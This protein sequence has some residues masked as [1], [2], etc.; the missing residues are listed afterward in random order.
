MTQ[1]EE[2]ARVLVADVKEDFNPRVEVDEDRMLQFALLLEEGKD[3][4]RP[5]VWKSRMLVVDGRTR[6]S[7]HRYLD[8]NEMDVIFRE[9]NSMEDALVDAYVANVSQGP[10]PP[11]E[12]DT[13]HTIKLLLRGGFGR[14]K[15]AERLAVQG[16]LPVK[17]LR[18]FVEEVAKD[19]ETRKIN[20]AVNA[21][22]DNDL[23]LVQA[24]T[25]YEVPLDRLKETFK[26]RKKGT[27]DEGSFAKLRNQ[28]SVDVS[29]HLRFLGHVRSTAAESFE[30]AQL[31]EAE[32]VELL[33]HIYER[34][35]HML[36]KHNG[37]LD[38]FAERFPQFA[39]TVERYRIDMQPKKRGP[40]SKVKASTAPA[41]DAPLSVAGKANGHYV[42]DKADVALRKMGLLET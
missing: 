32:V 36:R 2:H 21:V 15:I 1:R 22:L 42:D 16:I 11:T 30:K 23:T 34:H 8:R 28:V 7:A 17:H 9:Y 6:I 27:Q 25:Q 14:E 5:I 38:E 29:S 19:E 4:G 40:K 24:A 3:L 33:L 31:S 18:R 37:G 10:K 12:A 13:R 35:Q 20:T 39:D 26:R 41:D